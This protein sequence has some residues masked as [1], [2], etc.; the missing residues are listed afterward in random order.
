MF[1]PSASAKALIGVTD[2]TYS[3]TFDPTQNQSFSL[4]P[5]RLDMPAYA[6][7]A[8][9]TSGYGAA[10]WNTGCRPQTQPVTLTVVIK[11]AA[12][13][14]PSVNFSP[15]MRF[16]PTKTVQLF[17][18]APN[19]SRNDARN[20]LMFYCPDGGKC[21]DESTTDSSLATFIDYTNNILFRRVKHFSG[22]T[23]AERADDG[24]GIIPP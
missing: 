19:V 4:G 22:Y 23:V 13:S 24:S 2:G 12:T 7:C 1:V 3:V 21:L 16:N 8:L 5:N 18:Y 9:V 20:W 17:M 14:N 10:Y 15:A 6:I 11:G